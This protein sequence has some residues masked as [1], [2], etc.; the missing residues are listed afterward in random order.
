MLWILNFYSVVRTSI[1]AFKTVNALWVA[2]FFPRQIENLNSHRT[3]FNAK[4]A[5]AFCA[6][7]KVSA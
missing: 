7:N 3:S 5:F 1:H 4:A 6:F 2:D